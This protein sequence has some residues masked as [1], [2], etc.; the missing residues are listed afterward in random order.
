MLLGLLLLLADV[1]GICINRIPDGNGERDRPTVDT[2]A[3]H[4][5]MQEENPMY[6][7]KRK[8]IEKVSYANPQRHSQDPDKYVEKTSVLEPIDFT[9]TLLGGEE[10]FMDRIRGRIN[11]YKQRVVQYYR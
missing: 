8:A 10:T 2:I 6:V 7:W 9:E 1:Q 11:R 5:G 4:P 3:K